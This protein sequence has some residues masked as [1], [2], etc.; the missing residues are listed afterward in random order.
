MSQQK[1]TYE[2]VDA[3]DLYFSIIAARYNGDLMEALIKRVIDTLQEKGASRANIDVTRVPGSNEIPYLAGMHGLSRQYDCVI[4]LGVV[5]AGATPHHEIIAHSTAGALH[6][7]GMTTETPVINGIIV[8][9]N[10]E[11]A[12]AR[13]TGEFDRGAEFAEAAVEMARHKVAMVEALDQLEEADLF[14]QDDDDDDLKQ[15]FRKN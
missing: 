8:V 4:A 5:I 7:A 1:P 14:E 13:V 15:L 12:E 6:S 9:L 2:D 3:S 11:Q 10:H